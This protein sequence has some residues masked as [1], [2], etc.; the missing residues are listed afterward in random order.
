MGETMI[1]VFL[2]EDEIVIRNS[3]HKMIPWQEHGYELAGEAADG[4]I[5]LPL[6]RMVK[7]DVLITDI[8]MPFMDGLALSKLVKKE[9]PETKIVIISGHDDFEYARQAISLG[10]ERYLLKPIS[11]GSFIEVLKDIRIKQEI[12]YEQK[13]YY[14]KFMNELQEFEQ[15][16][17]RDLFEAMVSGHVAIG[18]IYEKAEKLHIDITAQYYNIVLF[19]MNSNEKEQ[20]FYNTYSQVTVDLQIRLE[21]IFANRPDYIL[22]RNQP[23]SY[24][25][26]IKG[27]RDT[28]DRQTDECV[29][30][31]KEFFKDS[32][33]AVD[34]FI[35]TGQSVERISTLTSC[36]Q[37]AMGIFAS[38]YLN[39]SRTNSENIH[40]ENDKVHLPEEMDIK[41]IDASIINTEI[42]LDFLS[43]ALEEEVS[44]FVNNYFKMIGEEAVKS[45]IFRQYILLNVHFTTVSFIQKLGFSKE[46]LEHYLPEVCSEM[47]LSPQYAMELVKNILKKGISLRDDSI[48]SRYKSV[49]D[50]AIDYIHKN[51]MDDSL[52]LNK[53]AC[54]ANV[55]AN[56]FS[57]LFSQERKKTFIE[58][59]TELRMNKAKELLRCTDMRSGEIALEVGYKDSHYFSFLFKKTQGCTPSDY[60]NKKGGTPWEF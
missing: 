43:H 17:R 26:L 19:S 44:N 2:V 6:I 57:A 59:L 4:E 20:I 51:Y 39:K 40:C 56:H 28:I 29:N 48:R 11:R 60:R 12:E 38:R 13:S 3:I 9:L 7:P 35:C 54:A 53:V 36:Y 52:S 14:E 37:S 50:V 49:I 21:R 5:A 16:S 27:K 41:N 18:I 24:A 58:Y 55:S 32:S 46:E 1:K 8:K 25:I 45:R 34:W 30:I 33:K 42:I 10:V 31:L 22:F 47:V 15:H 23:L